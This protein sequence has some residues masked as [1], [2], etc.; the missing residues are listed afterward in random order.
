MKELERFDVDKDNMS[1]L[2][3]K[4]Q[5]NFDALEEHGGGVDQSLANLE[6]SKAKQTDLDSL[7]ARVDLLTQTPSGETEGN[8]ELLDIRVDA[9]GQTFS[10]AGEAVRAITKGTNLKYRVQTISAI[11]NSKYPATTVSINPLGNNTAFKFTCHYD[12]SYA[13]ARLLLFGSALEAI[14]RGDKFRLA[15]YS[16]QDVLLSVVTTNAAG[17]GSTD[18]SVARIESLRTNYPLHANTTIYVEVD[19][20]KE[21]Y[22][23][24][25]EDPAHITANGINLLVVLGDQGAN[26]TKGDYVI[27][28]N[29]LT[30]SDYESL[31]DSEYVF[32]NAVNAVNAVNAENAVNAVNAEYYPISLREGMSADLVTIDSQGFTNIK[33]DV[34]DVTTRVIIFSTLSIG[35]LKDYKD[36]T[37]LV[38]VKLINSGTA[39]EDDLFSG[40]AL[41]ITGKY[42]QQWGSDIRIS[43]LSSI[44]NTF[45]ELPI[46]KSIIQDLTGRLGLTDDS[47][48]YLRL[49]NMNYYQDLSSKSLDI[50]IMLMVADSDYATNTGIVIAS[51]L[52]GFDPNNLPSNDDLKSYVKSDD[53]AKTLKSYSKLTDLENL[54]DSKTYQ[55]DKENITSKLDNIINNPEYKPEI[56]CWGDSLTA[57]GG[58]TTKLQEL[59]GLTVYNGGTGGEGATTI[60][61]RQ[62]ADVIMLNDVTIPGDGTEVDL[63]TITNNVGTKPTTFEGNIVTPLLQGGSH[64][65]PCYVDKIPCTMRWDGVGHPTYTGSWKIK[66][67]EIGD[68]IVIDRPTALVTNF[69]AIHNNPY[70]MIIYIGQNGWGSS[71]VNDLIRQHRLM[72]EHAHA[73]HVIVLGLSS[74]TAAQRKPYEDAMKKEFGRYFISLREYLAHPIYD[75][76]GETIKS[77]YGL[78]DQNLEPGSKE[79]NDVVYN[80]LE[81]IAVGTV[82]HQILA[83]SVHYT[84]GTKEVIGKLIYKRCQ[85]LN[86]F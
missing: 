46:S 23:Q 5:R 30:Y 74:G 42:N 37:K 34:G 43:N 1:N 6:N 24:F 35:K 83:D 67:N 18:G 21:I 50:R 71:D 49:N 86:I 14:E 32:S 27:Y 64:F 10:S 69:D 62:G 33:F 55:Q 85:E 2:F 60:V 73:K 82:P 53:L 61:A 76:D 54:V 56:V 48:L 11:S 80:A 25:F 81:E 79:Y 19:L 3:D 58:W 16:E 38:L 70:L 4:T 39:Q 15:L 8:A 68:D 75:T 63:F 17:W 52:A 59:S 47:D 40:L 65:N 12:A 22:S 41:S 45:A 66:R 84:A 57:G 28:G 51:K 20:S 44:N 9:H 29:L 72:I 13:Y 36:G 77:C 78:A 26:T 7:K 31:L